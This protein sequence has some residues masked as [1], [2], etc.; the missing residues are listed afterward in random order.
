MRPME[1]GLWRRRVSEVRGVVEFRAELLEAANAVLVLYAPHVRLK[2]AGGRLWLCYEGPAG[3]TRPG[4]GRST[5]MGHC[6][7]EERGRD[8]ERLACIHLVCA[9]CAH[10]NLPKPD[11]LSGRLKHGP[12]D[13]MAAKL[14]ARGGQADG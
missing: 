11:P 1:S 10:G 14:W 9:Y 12:A 8:A 4:A 2:R 6:L 13:C 5:A 7:A 3:A